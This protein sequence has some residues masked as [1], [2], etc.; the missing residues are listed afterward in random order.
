MLKHVQQM[1]RATIYIQ[2][3]EERLRLV[4]IDS[5]MVFDEKP[6]LAVDKSKPEKFKMVAIGDAAVLTNKSDHISVLNPFSHLR[7]LCGDFT[8]AEMLLKEV[9][10]RITNGRFISPAPVVVMHPMERLEGGLTEVEK[11]LFH[12]LALEAGAR[13]V[14]VHVG[15]ELPITD[16]DFNNIKRESLK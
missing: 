6:Y 16:F 4:D 14:A 2:L 3:W 11:R 1:F 13:D 10:R 15:D 12:E 8:H 7:I 5:G 9:I